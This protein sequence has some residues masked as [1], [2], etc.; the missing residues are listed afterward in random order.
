MYWCHGIGRNKK[1][2]LI[3]FLLV[4]LFSQ[5]DRSCDYVM[6]PIVRLIVKH[7]SKGVCSGRASSSNSYE[8]RP[9]MIYCLANPPNPLLVK[10]RSVNP[11]RLPMLAWRILKS[12]SGFIAASFL[13]RLGLQKGKLALGK[14][15]W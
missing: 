3:P 14:A 12:H 1:W 5:M 13:V 8:T 11:G 7:E 9:R 4:K 2:K 6:W 10:T 15:F